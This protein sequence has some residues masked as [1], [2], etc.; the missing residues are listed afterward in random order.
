MYISPD[1]PTEDD[2]IT[3]R[4]YIK[5]EDGNLNYVKF[6]WQEGNRVIDTDTTIEIGSISVT[7]LSNTLNHQKI[8]QNTIITCK[9]TVVDKGEKKTEKKLQVRVQK[10]AENTAPSFVSLPN[11][12]VKIG[13]EIPPINLFLYAYDKEDSKNLLQFDLISQSDTGVVNCYIDNNNTI[14]SNPGLIVGSSTITVQ[15]TDSEGKTG[16][17]NF[18]VIVEK[19][20]N[21]PPSMSVIPD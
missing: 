18:E 9:V 16:Q 11:K 8:N 20:P 6:E 5:D 3:C 12:N 15:V 21:D 2:D 10:R 13:E 14:K 1:S 4:V 7:T 17:G 19:T